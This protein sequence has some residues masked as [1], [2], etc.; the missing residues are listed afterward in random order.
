MWV[1]VA[2]V[3]TWG[4]LR[5]AV[6][7]GD[8]FSLRNWGLLVSQLERDVAETEQ[9]Y[10]DVVAERDEL[11]SEVEDLRR[12]RALLRAAVAQANGALSVV[13]LNDA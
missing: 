1:C 3:I 7:E 9:S 4:H 12:E 10:D 13:N 6:G 8:D 11:R 2:T 5:G